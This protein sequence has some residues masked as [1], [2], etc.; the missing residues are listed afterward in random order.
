MADIVKKVTLSIDQVSGSAHEALEFSRKSS[1]LS[2]Q[3]GY[4]PAQQFAAGFNWTPKSNLVVSGRY[5]YKYLNDKDGNYGLSQDPTSS[6]TSRQAGL[7]V[8]PR[9]RGYRNV[10]STFGI[11]MTLPLPQRLLRRDRRRNL[12][13]TSTRS[14]PVT[15]STGSPTTC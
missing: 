8:P 15:R 9:S 10:T 4:T 14:R 11:A 2:V 6:L 3:G 5:G 7:P 12:G 13:A 1:D